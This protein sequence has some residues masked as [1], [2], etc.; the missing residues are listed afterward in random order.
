MDALRIRRPLAVLA[1]AVAI[2][3]GLR[4]AAAVAQDA[5][6]LY[7]YDEVAAVDARGLV[8]ALPSGSTSQGTSPAPR[9]VGR[10]AWAWL[11]DRRLLLAGGST[12]NGPTDLVEIVEYGRATVAA[13]LSHR[14]RPPRPPSCRMVSGQISGGS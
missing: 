14:D 13:A 1:I 2:S 5:V 3:I 10:H 11:A 8:G 7:V 4:S 12:Q 6:V 9:G